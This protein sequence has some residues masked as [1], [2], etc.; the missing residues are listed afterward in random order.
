MEGG[1]EWRKEVDRR[2]RE[3]NVSV[4]EGWRNG[5]NGEREREERERKIKFK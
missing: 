3:Y 5:M 4:M 1:E 2:G